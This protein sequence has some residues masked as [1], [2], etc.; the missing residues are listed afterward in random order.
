ML[1]RNQAR[2]VA[3][4]SVSLKPSPSSSLPNST[5]PSL[6]ACPEPALVG[7]QKSGEVRSPTRFVTSGTCFARL[8]VSFLYDQSCIGGGAVA[9]DD[10]QIYPPE[11]P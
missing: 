2:P 11:D 3:G 8:N 4:D 10:P 7:T 9:Q 1:K 5:I 6:E